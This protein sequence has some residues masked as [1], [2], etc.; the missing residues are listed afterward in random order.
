LQ[1]WGRDFEWSWNR[2]P[3]YDDDGNLIRDGFTQYVWNAE[4]RL[5]R[6]EPVY[7]YRGAKRLEFTYDHQG[8]RVSKTVSTYQQRGRRWWWRGTWRVTDQQ[9][10]VYDD[11]NL[12]AVFETH[13]SSLS[14]QA[15]HV[16]GLDLSQS[17]Q[18]AG[19]VGG[20]LSTTEHTENTETVSYTTYDANGNVSEYLAEDGT[21]SAHY[22]YSPFGQL[23]RSTGPQANTFT[24]R[25][26]TK[27]QDAETN[28]YYYGYRYYD[29]N[30]GR[31]LN[32]DPIG[33]KGGRNLYA[34]LNNCGISKTDLF[35][36]KKYAWSLTNTEPGEWVVDVVLKETDLTAE[37]S[38]D[39]RRKALT[40]NLAVVREA[41]ISET[42]GGFYQVRSNVVEAVSDL[43][44]VGDSVQIVKTSRLLA[45]G[46]GEA[47]DLLSFIKWVNADEPQFRQSLK[48]AVDKFLDNEGDDKYCEC[49]DVCLAGKAYIN[50]ID[51]P[52]GISNGI[53]DLFWTNRVCYRECL[54]Y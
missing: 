53:A 26:S 29:T 12:I 5:I 42:R 27:Y 54:S 38:N 17:L 2:K 52:T 45:V 46:V 19:G 6:I 20:L 7:P 3:E 28:L 15:S 16:W 10:F 14:L 24:F 1:C 34:F 32:R 36:L 9:H 4:N 31:W 50:S 39:I 43:T 13:P 51:T 40:K 8:R 30:I 47:L 11:W 48:G 23:T 44:N 18:G 41:V 21:L 37:V 49:V 22:E 35:G 33:G 25:F